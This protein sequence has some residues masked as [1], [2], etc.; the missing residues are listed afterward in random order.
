MSDSAD[1]LGVAAHT[2]KD[3]RRQRQFQKAKTGLV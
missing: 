2:H 3:S 1:K